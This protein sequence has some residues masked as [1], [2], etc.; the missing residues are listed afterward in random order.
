MKDH[1]NK[2]WLH[3]KLLFRIKRNR[4]MAVPVYEPMTPRIQQMLRGMSA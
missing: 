4:K 2:D 3:R 1:A